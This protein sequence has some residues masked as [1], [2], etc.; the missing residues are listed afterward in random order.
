MAF[1]DLVKDFDSC[2]DILTNGTA[3]ASLVIRCLELRARCRL[4]SMISEQRHW[5]LA[6]RFH[7][8][9]SSIQ[10]NKGISDNNR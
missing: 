3:P 7:S 1:L 2:S 9:S 5:S 8:G 4:K 10:E 6:L